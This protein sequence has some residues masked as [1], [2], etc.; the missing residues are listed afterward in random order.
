L[1]RVTYAMGAVFS[2]IDAPSGWFQAAYSHRILEKSLG[3]WPSIF[4]N[5][6]AQLIWPAQSG[7]WW[8]QA[9]WPHPTG[10]PARGIRWD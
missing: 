3:P 8:S 4:D 6:H 5:N 1:E 2:L 10:I 7:H 9:G